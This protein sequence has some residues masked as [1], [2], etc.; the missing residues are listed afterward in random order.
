MTATSPPAA[1]SRPAVTSRPALVV[2]YAAVLVCAACGLLY[3]LALVALGGYLIGSSIEQTAIVISVSMFAMGV[4]A[5]I[6]KP[7]IAR[8]LRA[9]V[10]VE[11]ALALLGAAAVPLLYWSFAWLHVYTAVMVV[12]AFA[13]GCLVGAEVPLLVELLQ[14]LRPKQASHEIANL[15]AVD[16]LGALLGGLAFPFLL[17]PT[18]GLL[19][20][21]IAIAALNVVAALVVAYAVSRTLPPGRGRR[22]L[23]AAY[24]VG[25]VLLG[26]F[27]AAAARADE[28]E[29]SARQMLFRDPIIKAE[30]SKYQDIVIT[31]GA[32]FGAQHQ[33]VRLFL[34]G[35]LQLSSIDEYRYHE[36]LVHPALDGRRSRVLILGGGDGL[37]LR[38]VLRY[39]DVQS[40]TLVDLDDAVVGLARR[41]APLRDLNDGAFE[42][43]R[44]RYVAADAFTWV[45]DEQ[46]RGTEFDAV[47][48][49]F[50]D[51][52]ATETAK[53]YS[54]EMYA[55]LRRLLAPG[56]HMA[57]QSGSPFFGPNAFWSIH[58]TLRAAGLSAV[59]YHADVPSFGDW[60]FNLVADG[61]PPSPTLRELPPGLRYLTPATW[62]AAK[63]FAP[64]R[65]RRA[66]VGVSTL[67]R[68]RILDY[69]REP[70]V[71]Y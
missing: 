71:G 46:R 7:L 22:W 14:R 53:L 1:L 42:D 5:L 48:V 2:V 52:D 31:R 55:M 63:A 60:G 35:D 70:W 51:P 28:F 67:L 9:F 36:L 30:R 25:A 45:R 54:V 12:V 24:A 4:G 11:F 16:Y 44:V 64:D 49:D 57:V 39:R 66:D 21:T 34:N 19:V 29:L 8:P 58:N 59:P 15:N 65:A 68:P 47:I 26:L 13:I 20:G 37:A 62:E 41:F 56:G 33:D 32:P 38:E 10:S 27:A 17:L 50:P 61:R 3:E 23:P 6:A 18:L 40:A 69:S 43:P